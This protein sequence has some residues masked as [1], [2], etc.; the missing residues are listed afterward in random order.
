MQKQIH[1][2]T[3]LECGV[4]LCKLKVVRPM[5]AIWLQETPENHCIITTM[6]TLKGSIT[7]STVADIITNRWLT[8]EPKMMSSLGQTFWGTF[9]W[10][11][12]KSTDEVIS[13]CLSERQLL[14]GLSDREKFNE[15]LSEVCSEALPILPRAAN[16]PLWR[17]LVVQVVDD[18]RTHLLLRTHHVLADGTAL[19]SRLLFDL[20][21][22]NYTHTHTH[23]HT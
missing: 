1:C 13:K 20:F 18:K 17:L 10:R 5:D 16:A 6:I 23:T 2:S 22:I 9:F 19:I 21:D 12:F 15:F 4:Q 3:L 11:Q 8:T 14:V 7:I